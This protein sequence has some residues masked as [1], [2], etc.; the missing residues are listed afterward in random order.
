M[1]TCP[2]FWK[3][4]AP[5]ARASRAD[6]AFALFLLLLV[7]ILIGSLWVV[8]KSWKTLVEATDDIVAENHRRKG[9]P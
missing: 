2:T 5:V 7:A 8:G 4:C 6:V 9:R 1:P 3:P